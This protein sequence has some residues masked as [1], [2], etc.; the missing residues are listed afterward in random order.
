MFILLKVK[1]S[2]VMR[3]FIIDTRSHFLSVEVSSDGF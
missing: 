3:S 2:E 1:T